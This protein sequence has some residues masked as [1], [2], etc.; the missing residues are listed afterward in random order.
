MLVL[1]TVLVLQLPSLLRVLELEAG[2]GEVGH[3]DLVVPGDVQG[4]VGRVAE[5]DATVGALYASV[6]AQDVGVG[7]V[8]VD[9][10]VVF[11]LT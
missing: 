8:D 6:L 2:V 10:G 4:L 5:D 9:P 3:L 1:P 7:V 11:V